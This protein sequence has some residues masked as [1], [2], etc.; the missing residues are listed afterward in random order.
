MP[1]GPGN[2]RGNAPA[3]KKAASPSGTGTSHSGYV[4]TTNLSGLAKAS[5]DSSIYKPNYDGTDQLAAAMKKLGGS[6]SGGSGSGGG[7]GYYTTTPD[8]R[9]AAIA[10]AKKQAAELRAAMKAAYGNAA[11]DIDKSKL[12]IDKFYNG[13]QKNAKKSYANLLAS[14][15]GNYNDMTETEAAELHRLGQDQAYAAI[16]PGQTSKYMDHDYATRRQ[17]QTY[18]DLLQLLQGNSRDFAGDTANSTRM[19]GANQQG[20]L[21]KAL[22][23]QISQIQAGPG[24]SRTYHSGGGSGSGGS[25]GSSGGGGSEYKRGYGLVADYVKNTF[26]SK[27]GRVLD[28]LNKVMNNSSV[29]NNGVRDEQFVNLLQEAL[30]QNYAGSNN[31]SRAQANTIAQLYTGRY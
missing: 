18:D 19:A 31:T 3:K 30:N 15:R 2:P 29:R 9:P 28:S 11:S 24:G 7:G 14:L 21:L 5:K 4:D 17:G 8:P 1:G 22:Q 6:G 13:T 26:G 25:G 27:G 10:A 23:A 20:D 12:D 16:L